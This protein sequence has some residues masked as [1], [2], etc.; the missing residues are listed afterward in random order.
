VS[1]QQAAEKPFEELVGELERTVER[2]EQPEIGLEDALAVYEEGVKIL[3]ECLSRLQKAEGRV[4]ML[5][6]EG[7]ELLKTVPFEPGDLPEG[8]RPAS[9]GPEDEIEEDE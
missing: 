9:G 5:V 4:E 8:A 2:L 7:D 6:Q 3:R 1:D